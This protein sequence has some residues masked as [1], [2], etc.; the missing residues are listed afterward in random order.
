MKWLLS[1]WGTQ[2]IIVQT[3]KRNTSNGKIEKKDVRRQF[4][5]LVPGRVGKDFEL[6]S[7]PEMR[8]SDNDPLDASGSAVIARMNG[9]SL[10]PGMTVFIDG[11]PSFVGYYLIQSV[12][13]EELSP[14]PVSISFMTPERD[15]KDIKLPGVGPIFEATGDMIGPGVIIPFLEEGI[16]VQEIGP[17]FPQYRGN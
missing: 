4:I 2:S 12:D 8:K 6:M 16:T 9:T 14:N 15:P 17:P 11:I 13:Y 1:K 3:E 10:R 7:L 5:P